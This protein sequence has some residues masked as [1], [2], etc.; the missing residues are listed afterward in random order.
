MCIILRIHLA[1]S[2]DI[3]QKI[4]VDF[5]TPIYGI[6]EERKFTL[7]MGIRISSTLQLSVTE[8]DTIL[9]KYISGLV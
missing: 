3:N 9:S 8:L 7:A 5:Q 4:F 1:V 6:N 2:I